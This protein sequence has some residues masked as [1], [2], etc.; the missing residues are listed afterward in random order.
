MKKLFKLFFLGGFSILMLCSC[1]VGRNDVK[2]DAE[3]LQSLPDTLRQ[4]ALYRMMNSV[5]LY[6]Q[7]AFGF[8]EPLMKHSD[9]IIMCVVLSLIFSVSTLII[10]YMVLKARNRQLKSELEIT[11][12]LLDRIERLQELNINISDVKSLIPYNFKEKKNPYLYDVALLGVGLGFAVFGT[13]V[14]EGFF[15]GLGLAIAAIGALRCL[16]RIIAYYNNR[17]K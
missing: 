11:E 4:D 6:N 2:V 1:N 8:W 17:N 10:I 9:D 13:N 3:I 12:K 15:T 16:V 7:Q 14:H 5:Q